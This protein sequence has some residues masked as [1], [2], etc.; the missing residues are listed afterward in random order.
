VEE[1]ERG[2]VGRREMEEGYPD[3]NGHDGKDKHEG[4][5][6]G[7]AWGQPPAFVVEEVSASKGTATFA[8][9]T[10]P[11]TPPQTKSMFGEGRNNDN[12]FALTVF[13][14]LCHEQEHFNSFFGGGEQVQLIQVHRIDVLK[15]GHVKERGCLCFT[16]L[17]KSISTV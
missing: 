15:C 1:H 4:Y 2:G 3:G 14:G 13:D 6:V 12:K 7:C 11:P 8:D 10:P 17:F 9:E 16:I 5:E